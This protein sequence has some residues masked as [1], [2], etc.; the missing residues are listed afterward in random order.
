M[1]VVDVE[2]TWL[3]NLRDLGEEL[4]ETFAEERRAISALDHARLTYLAVHKHHLAERLAEARATTP[5][6]NAPLLKQL[7]A[8]L[9]VEA[10]ANAML[11]TVA[12]EA[13]RAM[14][15]YESTGGYDRAARRTTQS[16]LRLLATY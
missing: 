13:V 5:A 9:R 6:V 3:T 8:A 7:F 11:A 2:S 1:S 12:T 4:R 14:L 15:G 16:P 10:Q